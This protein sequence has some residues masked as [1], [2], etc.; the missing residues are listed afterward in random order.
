MGYIK[1]L[2]TGAYFKRYQVRGSAVSAPRSAASLLPIPL[3]AAEAPLL[4]R[5]PAVPG[6]RSPP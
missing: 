4:P 3:A 1:V 5:R 2:K 6:A